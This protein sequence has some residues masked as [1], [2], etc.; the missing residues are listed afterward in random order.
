MKE[1]QKVKDLEAALKAIN[2]R[3]QQQ[4]AKIDKVNAK[5]ELSKPA[6]RT[7]SNE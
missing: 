2:E 6:P 1:H 4:D 7:V 5:I 3:V